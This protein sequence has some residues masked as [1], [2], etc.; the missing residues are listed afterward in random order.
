MVCGTHWQRIN[1]NFEIPVTQI[2]VSD[3]ALHILYALR[4][5]APMHGLH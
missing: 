4:T 1:A 5:S 2:T 3:F